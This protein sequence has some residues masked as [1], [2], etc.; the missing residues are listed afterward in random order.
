MPGSRENMVSITDRCASGTMAI[1]ALPRV[2]WVV[3]TPSR[4]TSRAST[5]API[6]AVSP[7]SS[8]VSSRPDRSITRTLRPSPSPTASPSPLVSTWTSTRVPL[9]SGSTMGSRMVT[10]TRVTSGSCG[11][12]SSGSSGIRGGAIRATAR[13]RRRDGGA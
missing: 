10:A 9:Q 1:P 5:A 7:G 12:Q 2:A 6:A 3:S 11:R 4:T 13:T 8:M